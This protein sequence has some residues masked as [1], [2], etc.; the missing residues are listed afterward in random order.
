MKMFAI[1]LAIPFVLLVIA[2]MWPQRAP[3]AEGMD[4]F[5]QLAQKNT[6][7]PL[8][9]LPMRDGYALPFRAQNGPAGAPQERPLLVM[10]H[11]SG[12]H[13]MQF[14]GLAA[15]LA[16]HTDILIPDL[17]GH[18]ASPARRGDV[19]YI[20]QLEDDLAD[21]ITARAKPGQK[22]ILLGHSSGGG[23]VARFAGGA[24]RGLISGAVLLAPFLHHSAPTT[25]IGSGG[26]AQ[27]NL[28]RIIGLSILNR[29]GITA[30]NGLK[31]VRFAMPDA[32]MNGPLGHTATTTY[33]YRLNTS[34][35]P[36]DD[37]MADLAA[38]PTY[39][40]VAG[41][42]DESFV[43]EAYAPLLGSAGAKGKAVVLPG[44]TH[45]GVVNDAQTAA[46]VVQYLGHS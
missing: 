37:Y 20:G 9:S 46:L 21:L 11:G 28:P 23:L 36:R 10:I 31:I 30:L 7:I 27:I 43:A 33:S 26:W 45:L 42:A 6:P 12:W 16:P 40:L 22:V 25:R 14:E 13:G 24:H 1:G 39:L 41:S 35:A 8:Q 2:L 3:K 17:R 44:V 4:F 5:A 38:L 29:F 15:A 34:F 32:V 18:G 19:D